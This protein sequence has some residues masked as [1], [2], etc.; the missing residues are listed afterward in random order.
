[1]VGAVQDEG[2][3]VIGREQV[4][5]RADLVLVLVGRVEHDPVALLGGGLGEPVQEA[6]EDPA[7]DAVAGRLDPHR[8]QPAPAGAHLAGGLVGAVA[9]LRDRLLD[10]AAG[11][12][13]DDVRGVDDVGHGLPRD[14]GEPGHRGDRHLFRH[15]T[16]FLLRWGL[17]ALERSKCRSA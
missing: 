16:S 4:L 17:Q 1:V 9:E 2:V 6:V 10:A 14:L 8:D 5:V 15:R 7:V 13:A 12:L 11:L 3:E